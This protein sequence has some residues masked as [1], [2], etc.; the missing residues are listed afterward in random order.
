MNRRTFL[1]SGM[2][3]LGMAPLP[4]RAD[5]EDALLAR[6]R[7][8]GFQAI[9]TERTWLGRVRITASGDLGQREIILNPRTGEVLRDIIIMPDGSTVPASVVQIKDGTSGSNSG[10]GSNSGSGSGSDDKGDDSAGDGEGDK[11]D[12]GGDDKGGSNSGSGNSGGDNSGSG[13]GGDDD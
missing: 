13:G 1:C 3:A 4:G 6:L 8:E 11:G 12:D 7:A 10:T 5:I 9:L 2:V